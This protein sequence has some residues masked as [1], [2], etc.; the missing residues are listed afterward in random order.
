MIGFKVILDDLG[1]ETR[2]ADMFGRSLVVYADASGRTRKAGAVAVRPV[3]T[4]STTSGTLKGAAWGLILAGPLGVAIGSMVGGGMKVAFEL[5]TVDGDTLRCVASKGA[6]LRIKEKVEKS[7]A[8]PPKPKRQAAPAPTGP[9]RVG[10]ALLAGLVVLP[11]VFVWFLLRPRHTWKARAWGA[12]WTI[13]WLVALANLP[14]PPV[15]APGD[16][17]VPGTAAA[18]AR[19]D[20]A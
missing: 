15:E 4:E 12:V 14:S 11:I 10:K 18:S 16:A 20:G 19:S 7:P 8:L 1:I 13:L 2:G 6:Y 17:A 5:D 3:S 9:R